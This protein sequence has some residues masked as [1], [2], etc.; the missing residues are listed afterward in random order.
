MAGNNAELNPQCAECGKNQ[1]YEAMKATDALK[2]QH[3]EMCWKAKW[4]SGTKDLN[5]N[6]SFWKLARAYS[7]V[8]ACV[9]QSNKIE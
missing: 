9:A 7:I 4:A 6:N 3:T 8:D 5:V 1:P 2:Q